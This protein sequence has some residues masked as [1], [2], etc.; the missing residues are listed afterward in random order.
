MVIAHDLLPPVTQ[1]GAQETGRRSL[2]SPPTWLLTPA[3]CRYWL[4]YE[5]YLVEG[6]LEKAMN[7]SFLKALVKNV[8]TNISDDLYFSLTPS[9]VKSSPPTPTSGLLPSGTF[10]RILREA[11][12]VL[13][14]Y[15]NVPLSVGLCHL[16]S[17]GCQ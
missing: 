1:A 11:W 17:S 7:L 16:A 6:S 2:Q 4:D 13:R 8:S 15:Q 14:T 5:N 12:S 10:F 9:Q 3:S